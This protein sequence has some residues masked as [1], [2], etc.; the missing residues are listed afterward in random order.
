MTWNTLPMYLFPAPRFAKGTWY[1]YWSKNGKDIKMKCGPSNDSHRIQNSFQWFYIQ[2]DGVAFWILW[3]FHQSKKGEK[4]AL[5]S[6]LH[7]NISSLWQFPRLKSEQP[8]KSCCLWL[9]FVNLSPGRR[10]AL[11]LASQYQ[12]PLWQFPRLMWPKVYSNVM[13][14]IINTIIDFFFLKTMRTCKTYSVRPNFS[15]EGVW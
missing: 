12:L 13:Q 4:S 11:K 2:R 6:S 1:M 10:N 14:R 8:A 3:I 7:L 9:F 15:S 5:H